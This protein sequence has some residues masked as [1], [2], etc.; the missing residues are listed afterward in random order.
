MPHGHSWDKLPSIK[1]EGIWK[2]TWRLLTNLRTW[3]D[4]SVKRA[5]YFQIDGRMDYSSQRL[6]LF[7]YKSR[8]WIAKRS[9]YGGP[10]VG[11]KGV[12]ISLSPPCS[13][14]FCWTFFS[15]T[16]TKVQ[17]NVTEGSAESIWTIACFSFSF[18]LFL[19]GGIKVHQGVAHLVG[20]SLTKNMFWTTWKILCKNHS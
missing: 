4:L 16:N 14:N 18:D 3:N 2:E 6:L 15:V 1:A 5:L 19:A 10:R 12:L 11:E 7:K 13:N 8:S 17:R 9:G 20:C